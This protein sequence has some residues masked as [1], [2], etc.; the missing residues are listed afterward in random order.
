MSSEVVTPDVVTPSAVD[1]FDTT[2]RDGAQFEGISLTVE[3]KLK[4]AEQL[5]WLGVRWI[6]GGYPQANPRDAVLF[7]RAVTELRLETA[8]LVAFGSTRR[9]LSSATP[10]RESAAWRGPGPGYWPDRAAAEL[11]LY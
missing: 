2:L 1:I 10:G 11:R 7:R 5:E 8:T 9:R 6:E 3:D 4:V